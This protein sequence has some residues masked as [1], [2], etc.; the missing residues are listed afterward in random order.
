MKHDGEKPWTRQLL[1]AVAA[2]L[3]VALLIAGVVSAFALGAAKVTGIDDATGTTTAEPSLVLPDDKPT[4]DATPSARASDPTPR[5][6]RKRPAITL[7]AEQTAVQPGGRINLTGY[8]RRGNGAL[9]QVQRLEGGWTDF[10]V[11]MSVDGGRFSTYIQT[12]RTGDARFRVVDKGAG[13][14]SNV[15]RV[16]IG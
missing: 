9:L 14:T 15:V 2:L 6:P 13:R 10:P 1:V 12:S 4:A 3:A 8:Y 16:T 5:A 11:T 7:R